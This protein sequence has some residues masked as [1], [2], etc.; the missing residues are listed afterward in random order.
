MSKRKL[1]V[2]ALALLAAA[3]VPIAAGA[4]KYTGPGVTTTEIKIGNTMPY[5][6]AASG[7]GPVGMSEGAY[8]KM[9]NDQGGVNGRKINFVT[10][11]DG[12]SPPRTVEQTRQLVEQ[13][14]VLAVFG[15]IGTP[16]NS[17]VHAYLNSRKVP[18]LLVMTG[19]TKWNDPAHFPWT[20]GFLPSYQTEGRIY[21]KYILENLPS[22]KIGVLYQN[23]D[24]GKDYLKGFHDGLGD[25]AAKLIVKEVSFEVTDPT[26]D[27]Q[28]VTL[29][30][31]GADVFF[32]VTTP[33]FAAQAIRKA[34]DIGWHP[35]HF[36]N[37]VSNSVSSVLTPAGL[38][39][40]VGLISTLFVKDPGDARWKDDAEMKA[41]LAFMDKYQPSANKG[42]LLNVWGYADASTLVQ[43][44]K[45]CG[46]D[47][48][49]DNVMKQA[50]NVHKFHPLVTLPGI[51]VNTSPT[52]WA[53]I[54]QLQLE[55]FDG[56]S[57]IPFGS[58][59]G[60]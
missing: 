21:A 45:Q 30:A 13:E 22:A 19:A 10:L 50:A 58:V 17:S 55:K 32:N 12:Y 56:K 51:E 44:L 24:Y 29:Q 39:K 14:G 28:I 47:L 34:G 46:D 53:V 9:I 4:Q 40:S 42:D 27:S 52:D 36:L 15:S 41:F 38:D 2:P 23:D 43:V 54:R 5:S 31:S 35:T 26:I 37:N 59:I 49:R 48:S 57:W 16:T 25:K 8:F 3:L 18:Q 11:D 60:G 7:Y 1:I 20:I 33:K 6:G